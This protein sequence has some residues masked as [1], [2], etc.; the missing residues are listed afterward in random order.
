VNEIRVW[1]VVQPRQSSSI[2]HSPQLVEDVVRDTQALPEHGVHHLV[3]NFKSLPIKLYC[4]M[5]RRFT[6]VAHLVAL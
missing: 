4:N 6:A 2:A 5:G 1:M 3:R